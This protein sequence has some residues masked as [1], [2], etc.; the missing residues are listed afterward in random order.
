MANPN[1]TDLLQEYVLCALNECM[2]YQTK[3]D[4]DSGTI[5]FKHEAIRE[6]D[7]SL[8]KLAQQTDVNN[9]LATQQQCKMVQNQGYE[10]N[11]EA[12]DDLAE[13]IINTLKAQ[14]R[15]KGNP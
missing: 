13:Q 9:F 5:E 4:H 7:A 2:R 12:L 11:Y 15:S 14:A 10:L 3:V 8:R 6:F 1:L